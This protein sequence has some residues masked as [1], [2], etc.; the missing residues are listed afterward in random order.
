[1]I[2]PILKFPNKI[3]RT[4]AK[5]IIFPLSKEII[6]LARDMA[7]TVRAADGI[8]L[9]APQVGKSVRLAVINLEKHGIDLFPLFNPKILKRSF[10]KEEV[11]EGC[12]SL[13]GIF[14]F[15]KRP[16]K[17]KIE[18]QNIDGKKI[19]F[20][21]DGWISRVIQ[22]ELDHVDGKLIIDHIKKFTQGKD[23]VKQWKKEKLL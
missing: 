19:V 7:D 12:L 20:E 4:S 16:K 3:L 14:G 21:D 17:V 9:A 22:H 18:T 8:G 13:P 23:I 15:V 10:K 5:E 2:L 11:E 6:K 1:M